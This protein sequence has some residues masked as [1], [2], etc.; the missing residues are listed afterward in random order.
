MRDD[1]SGQCGKGAC[2]GDDVNPGSFCLFVVIR[3]AGDKIGSVSDVDV[4]Y[5]RRDRGF[6]DTVRALAVPL[7][8]P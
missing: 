8:W 4:V 7:E 5:A 1:G 2:A 3:D 6:D